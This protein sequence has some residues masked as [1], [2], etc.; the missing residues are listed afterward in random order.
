MLAHHYLSALEFAR[1]AGQETV[2]LVENARTALA[3]AG[4]RALG[5]NAFPPAVR[6][7]EAALE[8]WP[9]DDG[10]RPRLLFRY[11]EAQ[12]HAGDE[13]GETLAAARDELLAAGDVE[14]AAEAIVMLGELIWLRGETDLGFQHLRSAVE[15]LADRPVSR[16]KAHV[17]C[18]LARFLLIAGD[19]EEAIRE[20]LE[21]L[22][23]ADDIGVAELRA[24]ALDSIGAARAAIGDV[25]G[26]TDLEESIAIATELNSLEVVR[27]YVNLGTAQTEVG[28][29]ERA[30]ELYERG[31]RAAKAFGDPDRIRWFEAERLYEHYWRGDWDEALREAAELMGRAETVSPHILHDCRLIRG[32]I[33]LARDELVGGLEDA[34]WAL[35]FARGVGSSQTLLPALA[36]RARALLVAAQADEASA[37]AGELLDLWAQVA[38]TAASYWTADLA[39]VLRLVGRGAEFLTAAGAG[40]RTRWL[41]AG[42]AFASGE[43][44]SAAE[45]YARIGSRPDE[46]YAH[47]CAASVGDPSAA[48]ENLTAALAFYREVGG[49]RFIREAEARAFS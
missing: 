42:E 11:G 27:G 20:G 44:G 24:H 30:F 29:L 21:A 25:R 15:L 17:Q 5:L 48:S 34:A 23:M 47:L 32:A 35:E 36:F 37:L 3:E 4:D 1:A 38:P 41:E 49:S 39:R 8:L 2:S 10:E 31:R 43:F 33:R 9:R 19:Y 28:D 18:S 46:A 7:Y 13:A 12:F 45:L 26:L 6:F 14:T 40:S 16:A 22:R